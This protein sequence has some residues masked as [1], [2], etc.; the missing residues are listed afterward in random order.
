MEKN[1]IELIKNAVNLEDFWNKASHQQR[2]EF[3]QNIDGND[4]INNQLKEVPF[5]GFKQGHLLA[6]NK[7]FIQAQDFFS[8]TSIKKEKIPFNAARL[9]MAM[10]LAQTELI[11]YSNDWD[12]DKLKQ[13]SKEY[14][15]VACELEQELNE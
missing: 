8:L 14:Y 10:K 12:N 4:E 5:S 2:F 11:K 7:N 9:G 6:M 15:E 13:K 3:L 1:T